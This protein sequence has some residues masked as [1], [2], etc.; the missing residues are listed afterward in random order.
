M[1]CPDLPIL[2][3]AAGQSRR[4]RGTDKLMEPVEGRPLVRRQAEIARAATSGP[5]FVTLPPGA[6]PRRDALAG[7]DVTPVSVPDAA[8][9]M[10]ASLRA[11]ITALPP[12]TGAAMILLGDLPELAETDLKTAL[13]AVDL[14]SETLAWRGATQ[15]GAPGHPLVVSAALFDGLKDLTGDEGGRSVLAE[16]G[17]RVALVPLPGERARADLDTPEDWARWRADRAR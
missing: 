11:G 15:T 2:I 3:L 8:R 16:A 4:M 5:V 14:N 12:G 7:L 17:D 6:H 10:S 13:Q 1:P 9:G